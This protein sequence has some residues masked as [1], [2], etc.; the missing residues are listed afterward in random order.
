[1]PRDPKGEQRPADVIGKAAPAGAGD[2]WTWT[3][4]DAE[5]KL[6]INTDEVFGTHNGQDE[7]EQRDHC[8]LTLGDFFS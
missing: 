1:M 7:I 8:A 5:T 6:I 4:L 3:A 2:T